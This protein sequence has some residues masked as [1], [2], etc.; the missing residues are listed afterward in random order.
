[1]G[2]DWISQD[3][4]QS[5]DK[6]LA[7]AVTAN[8]S[9][10]DRATTI[11][12][13]GGE[14]TCTVNVKQEG[15]A[16]EKPDDKPVLNI[17]PSEITLEAQGEDFD[18]T[19]ESNVKYT[20]GIE[21]DWLRYKT[22]TSVG[23]NKQETFTVDAN[24]STEE[25]QGTITISGG[26]L[27]RTVIVK[28]KGQVVKPEDP[29]L[30]VSQTDFSMGSKGGTISLTIESNVEYA[31]TIKD[32]WVK[33]T[34]SKAISSAALSFVIEENASTEARQTTIVISG[35]GLTR[36]VTVKQ[37]GQAVKPEDPV[38]TV[39]QTDFSVGSK[40]GTISLTI[41]SNVAYAVTIKDGWVKQT[42]P[43]AISSAD[44]SFVIE[45]NASTEA[46][47]TTI[48]ISGGGLTRTII[49]NQ[50][51]KAI[52]PVL[53]VAESVIEVEALG[54]N[55]DLNI[56]SNV[57]YAIQANES[58]IR[59]MAGKTTLEKRSFTVD[60]NASTEERQGTIT[61]SGG[62]LTRN[63]TVKQKGK[64]EE[65]PDGPTTGNTEDFEEE[66]ENW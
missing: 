38:L 15:K 4:A 53:I 24:T 44:L 27:T 33:Q 59:P 5:T 62:G 36:T 37:E 50:E 52:E 21:V 49:I 64:V 12:L 39:S 51:G 41:E 16:E 31:V 29:V 66:Q 19:I 25:R 28:Q 2:A 6:H 3:I 13:N 56:Q 42:N 58:W 45:E 46:R 57:K 43:K 18:L 26:G 14:L 30:T 65:K 7:F 23:T 17:S 8:T 54:G 48:F 61:I 1:M 34:N 22:T 63:V 60:S 10:D 20:I 47:Q 40:G 55:F 9:T 32:G 11:T 35:G